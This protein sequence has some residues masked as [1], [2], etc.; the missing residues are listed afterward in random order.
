[1]I[2]P[3][4]IAPSVLAAD[5]SRLGEEVARIEAHA[6][7]LH[8]DVMDGHFVP[9]LAIGLPVIASLREITQLPLDCHMMTLNPDRYLDPLKDAG[10]DIVTVHI[11][12]FPNPRDVAARAR[13][14]GLEFG[15]VINP[16]TPA[17]AVEPFVELTDMVLVMSVDPGFGGQQFKETVLGKVERLRKFIDSAGL[18]TDIEI[19][20]GIDLTTIR[21][22]RDAGAEVFV[23]GTS[24]FRADDPAAA[25]EELRKA[26]IV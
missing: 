1:M 15:L 10:A 2:K 21:S 4:R 16:P 7:L 24:V 18:D 20:G 13:A 22:A 5:F 8:V 6:D 23:A 25:V 14:A 17:E 26:M 3:P 19:D 12:V 11:E 9:N